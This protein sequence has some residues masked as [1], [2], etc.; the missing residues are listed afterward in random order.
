MSDQ[1]D[2]Q[3]SSSGETPAE[4]EKQFKECMEE[5]LEV[6]TAH[7]PSMPPPPKRRSPQ[8]PK[9]M[10][11]QVVRDLEGQ[12]RRL[13]NQHVFEPGV[14][15]VQAKQT[16]TEKI[17][18]VAK[19]LGATDYE[20]AQAKWLALKQH[21]LQQA[22]ETSI[23]RWDNDLSKLYK[24]SPPNAG[25]AITDNNPYV[26]L[27]DI[28]EFD[29]ASEV[30]P[31]F[32]IPPTWDMELFKKYFI[33]MHAEVTG[34]PMTFLGQIGKDKQRMKEEALGKSVPPVAEKKE[35]DLA[36][37]KEEIRA[38]AQTLGFPTIG[39]TKLDRRYIAESAD[40]ELPYDTLI[41]LPH[42]M[43]LDEFKKIPVDN[44]L[45]AFTSYRDGG[46]AVHEVADFI[47][48]KGYKCLARVSSD[49]AIKYAPHAVN[50]GMGNYSTFGICIFPELGTRTKVTGIITEAELPLDQPRDWNIEEF[51]AR[52]RCCQKTCPSGAIPKDEK[53]F[54]GA[55]KRQTYHQRCFE[56]MAT[57]Y[58][59]NLC[60]RICPFS[61][62]GWDQAMRALPQYLMYNV[63][64]DEVNHDLLRANWENEVQND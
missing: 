7:L 15:L 43:P 57:S 59:C 26:N 56:Y 18:E 32:D 61:V 45:M 29:V 5:L 27:V 19:E 21:M 38:Y 33:P 31:Y 20:T 42:E 13:M 34:Q 48:S 41:I 46:R 44:P 28:E 58:E 52:C 9:L 51:C 1:G 11:E 35:E 62:L 23:Y 22:D 8:P 24:L 10:R 12:V 60:C 64:R 16:L 25:K 49:G 53:R 55:L 50:A 36:K 40:D 3:Q 54:R 30:Y 47:R 2:P 63:Y 6:E 4:V 17:D 14:K 39:V 37:L